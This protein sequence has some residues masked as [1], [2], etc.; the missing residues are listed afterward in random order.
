MTQELPV[1]LQER[2]ETT[3]ERPLAAQRAGKVVFPAGCVGFSA[4]CVFQQAGRMTQRTTGRPQEGRFVFR[5]F[6]TLALRRR[7][8]VRTGCSWPRPA[9]RSISEF[10]SPPINTAKAV[11]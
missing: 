10:T 6:H 2:R 3:Q 9:S 4:S 8:L 7:R 5:G 1:V 11:R